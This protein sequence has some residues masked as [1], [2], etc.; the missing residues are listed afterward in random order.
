MSTMLPPPGSLREIAEAAST[1]G[2]VAATVRVRAKAEQFGVL[3]SRE[4]ARQLAESAL[5]GYVNALTLTLNK[6]RP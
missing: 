4:D 3:L 5:Q 6:E 1:H 2:L